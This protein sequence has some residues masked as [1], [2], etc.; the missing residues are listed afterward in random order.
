M[1]EWFI[2]EFRESLV[3]SVHDVQ[4]ILN[5]LATRGDL[6]MDHVGMFGEGS[7]ATIAILAAAVEPWLKVLDLLDPWGD[8]PDWLSKSS[9]IPKEERADLLK[10]E[11]LKQVELLEPIKW[12]PQLQSRTLRLQDALYD[13]VTPSTAKKRIESAMPASA[14]IVRYKDSQALGNVASEGKFFDW[15]KERVRPAVAGEPTV[16]VEMGTKLGPPAAVQSNR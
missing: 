11:F 2:S 16:R 6:D 1:R 13:K 3:S 15:V 12:L 8:W 5:Y 14:Q 4:M 7:G 10:A 9:L